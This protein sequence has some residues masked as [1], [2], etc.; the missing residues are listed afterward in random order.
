MHPERVDQSGPKPSA[1]TIPTEQGAGGGT[2]LGG[3]GATAPGGDGP[4][5][6]HRRHR[7]RGL[8]PLSIR[9]SLVLVVT[10][11]L[12]I[13]VILASTVVAHQA[14]QRQQ[15]DTAR[16]SSLLLDSLLRARVD[17]YD[18]Y[19]PSG[20]LVAASLY[21]VSELEVD[22][23]LGVNFQANLVTTRR[24][25]DQ[26][27]V[28]R[29][30]GILAADYRSLL[31]ER[32][33]VD[34]GT[35]TLFQVQSFF[36]TMGNAIDAR[37]QRTFDEL[38]RAN[39]STNT[40]STNADLSALGSSF[41]AFTSG[42]GEESLTSRGSLE[43][44][45]TAAPSPTEVQSLIVSNEQ[46]MTATAGFPG[47]LGPDGQRAWA[48]LTAE[49]DRT[50]FSRYVQLAIT[51]SL[52]HAPPPFA[53]NTTAI[54]SIGRAEVAWASSLNALVLA[55]SADLRAATGAQADA[56]TRSL[57]LEFLLMLFIVVVVVGGAMLLSRSVR[58]PL[59]HFVDAAQSVQAGELAL[60]RLDESG[61]REL[62]LAAGA[63]NEMLST[64]RAVQAQAIAMSVGDLDAPVLRTAL[65]GRTGSALQS[66]LSSLQT[67]VR[68]SETQREELSE[69]AT[70]DSLTALLNRGA[71]QEALELALAQVNRSAGDLELIVLFVDLDEL[72]S[73]NDTLGHDRGDAAIRAVAHALQSA[74]R[75]SDIVARFGGDEFVVGSVGRRDSGA[76][77]LLADRITDSLAGA[78]IRTDQGTRKVGASVGIAVS[79]P[80]DSSVEALIERAD[81]ALYVAKAKGRGQVR[82]SQ[83]PHSAGLPAVH[84]V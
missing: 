25:V 21:H 9:F 84:P 33:K 71:A 52:A 65:P 15:A 16:Q 35:T 48:A 27:A 54:A 77:A 64:L 42:L 4:H 46:F 78:E 60:P 13:I 49:D 2:V 26:Q 66:A 29:P 53:T 39:T 62:A 69:R 81:E 10:V 74:T 23:L 73:I 70:R 82:W 72:K 57:Y 47:A 3:P 7:L 14:S 67:S 51:T 1:N 6:P 37:W 18:E 31:V 79:E 59:G 61:P 68:K 76:S 17:I 80:F 20:A 36:N 41:A 30:G 34:K 58:R 56:A 5:G 24:A 75:A 44:V 8:F 32:R 83:S 38:V 45:L 50:G 11:P 63:F 22:E 28:F 43:T 12:A 55:S 19:I 40:S